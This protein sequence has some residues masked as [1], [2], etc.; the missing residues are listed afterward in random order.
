MY[1]RYNYSNFSRSNKPITVGFKF[2]PSVYPTTEEFIN[3]LIPRMP[4]FSLRNNAKNPDLSKIPY[5]DRT[6]PLIWGMQIPQINQFCEM[7]HRIY[8]SIHSLNDYTDEQLSKSLDEPDLAKLSI[9]RSSRDDPLLRISKLVNDTRGVK[10]NALA[11]FSTPDILV[12]NMNFVGLLNATNNPKSPQNKAMGVDVGGASHILNVFGPNVQ[13]NDYLGFIVK[14]KNPVDDAPVGPV[15]IEPYYGDRLPS[16]RDR[17]YT[18][19]GHVKSQG[20]FFC[21][22]RVIDNYGSDYNGHIAN[23]LVGN[24]SE[25]AYNAFSPA[26]FMSVRLFTGV[27]TLLH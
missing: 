3:Q 19:Y 4:I 27:H 17:I 24:S 2:L 10:F 8:S 18:G 15:V 7:S 16:V 12:D 5:Y 21:I 23:A 20:R 14:R 13:P 6:S 26:S 1:G 25:D 22:G 9:Y 11:R